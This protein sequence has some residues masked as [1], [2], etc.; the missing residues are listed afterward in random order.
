MYIYTTGECMD[1]G[2]PAQGITDRYYY[3][4]RTAAPVSRTRIAYRQLNVEPVAEYKNLTFAIDGDNENL[5]GFFVQLERRVGEL[6]IS[7]F[8]IGLTTLE[9]VFLTV[10]ETAEKEEA[11]E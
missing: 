11:D 9:E 7:N 8:Q 5:E 2:C 6:G 3:D 10:A 4:L 1:L